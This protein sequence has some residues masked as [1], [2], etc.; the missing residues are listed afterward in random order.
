MT[1]YI[2]F[3]FYTNN[4]GAV[5]DETVFSTLYRRAQL[6]L[7]AI[8]FNRLQKMTTIPEEVK[9]CLIDLVN[10]LDNVESNKSN[11]SG[12]GGNVTS[13]SNG[14]LSVSVE[15]ETIAKVNSDIDTMISDCLVDVYDDSGRN[16]FYRGICSWNN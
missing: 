11:L 4:G 10:Y 9:L 14:S 3:E 13:M 15:E 2:D 5:T 16:L 8:T 1:N 7:D 12:Y 6:R